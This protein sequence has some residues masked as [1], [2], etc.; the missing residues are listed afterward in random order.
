MDTVTHIQSFHNR[1]KESSFRKRI[2]LYNTATLVFFEFRGGLAWLRR[3]LCA[4]FPS[5]EEAD[6]ITNN[7]GAPYDVVCAIF[8]ARYGP[9]IATVLKTTSFAISAKSLA[10][11]WVRAE[12]TYASSGKHVENDVFFVKDLLQRR[13]NF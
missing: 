5:K 1:W 4:N 6:N 2:I 11:I 7:K 10:D 12:N 9:S 8:Q 3:I 13:L